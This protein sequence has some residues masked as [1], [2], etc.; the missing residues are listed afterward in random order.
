MEPGYNWNLALAESFYS[1]ESDWS[2]KDP[3]F[4]YMYEKETACDGK[5]FSPWLFRYREVSLDCNLSIPRGVK[6]LPSIKF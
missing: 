6:K 3:N 5:N 2:S 1:P 4:S